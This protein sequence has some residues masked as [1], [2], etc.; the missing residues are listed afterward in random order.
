VGAGASAELKKAVCRAL[1]NILKAS[2]LRDAID[3]KQFFMMIS[4]NFAA[5]YQ[6]GRL[7]LGPVWEALAAQHEPELLFGMFLKFQETGRQLGLSIAIPSTVQNLSEGQRALHVARFEEG[8]TQG[9]MWND[10]SGLTPLLELEPGEAV[11]APLSTADLKPLISEEVT[12]RVT[13]SIVQALKVGPAADRINAAQVHYWVDTH[14]AV[15]CDGAQLDFAPLHN[16]LKELNGV[17]DLDLYLSIVKLRDMLAPIGIE[18]IE[19]PLDISDEAR[20]QIHQQAIDMDREPQTPSSLERISIKR[21]EAPKPPETV[22]EP[23]KKARLA[24]FGLTSSKGT[25][26]PPM[27]RAIVLAAVLMILGAVG[28]VTRLNRTLEPADFAQFPLAS[29]AIVQGTF[30]GVLDA[31]RWHRLRF[32]DREKAVK[33]LEGLLRDKG[34]IANVQIR[35]PQS[36]LLLVNAGP[37]LKASRE[38]MSI[39]LAKDDPT[40]PKDFAIAPAGPSGAHPEEAPPPDAPEPK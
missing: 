31:K 24:A 12:K 25:N 7:D 32:A 10:R 14:F 26:A 3:P 6:D 28:W 34:L 30:N 4:A 38:L 8:A 17:G 23:K 13:Q 19:P 29:A 27:A 22:G 33:D 16:A 5:L 37:H 1:T 9:P 15:L 20:Q 21:E 35:D 2:P 40:I 11:P 39:Q 18:L 36:R